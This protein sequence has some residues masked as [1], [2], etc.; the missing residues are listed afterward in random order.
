LLL[1]TPL[2]YFVFLQN[3]KWENSSGHSLVIALS[4]YFG[5]LINSNAGIL[6]KRAQDRC[7]SDHNL[8]LVYQL[9]M[10]IT[11]TLWVFTQNTSTG[12][13]QMNQ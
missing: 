1:I 2:T 8:S 4:P 13:T 6:G 11:Y 10:V 12:I 3:E 7:D 9:G 5:F